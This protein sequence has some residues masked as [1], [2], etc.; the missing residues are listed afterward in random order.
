MTISLK[1]MPEE[2]GRLVINGEYYDPRNAYPPG[3]EVNVMVLPQGPYQFTG[4]KGD[5]PPGH[6]SDM[7]LLIQSG[8][9]PHEITAT[10]QKGYPHAAELVFD[11]NFE[12]GNGI[13][14]YY[15]RAARGLVI[16]PQQINLADNIWWHFKIHNITPG[17]FLRLELG[18]WPVAGDCQPVYSYDGV[19][20][21]RMTGFKSP[22]IQRFDAP[23]V[24]ISR[25][26]P[27]PYSRVLSLA[28][29][30]ASPL[31]TPQ[32]LAISE[33]GRPVKMLRMTDPAAPDEKKRIIWVMARQ[34]AFESHSSYYAEGLAKWL[35]GSS[36][37]ARDV[38]RH[39][40]VYV[41]PVM[42]VDNVFLGGSG[43]EQLTWDQRRVDFNRQWGNQ[44]HWA[45]IRAAKQMLEELSRQ[46]E[47]AAFID[48]HNPWY[49]DIPHWHIP[50]AF[51]KQVS[52]FA[53]LW[54][55]EL[56]ATGSGEQWKHWLIIQRSEGQGIEPT[57][58]P[59][60]RSAN[61]YAVANL[62]PQRENRLCFTIE[63]PHWTDGYG[64]PITIKTLYAYGEALGRALGA[65]LQEK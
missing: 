54:S 16:E 32:I 50:E 44:S 3:S 39:F 25:N 37:Q 65:Y 61:L 4:W 29:N 5:V 55:A 14:R 48:L 40:I 51:E 9:Q 64:H 8:S 21:Q 36:S 63:T 43:K 45:A 52:D 62:F 56:E 7:P 58:E 53:P 18:H 19:N 15:D 30:L 35:T 46:H 13:L 34:H 28:E 17:E 33:G 60:L 2:G 31:V 6:E 41:T 20:W 1:M 59:N 42:D 49:P 38:L 10:F 22:Y 47:I 12:N 23:S 57:L 11:S 27:Y 24:E 26:T